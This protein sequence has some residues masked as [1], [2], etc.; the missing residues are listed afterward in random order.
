[1]GQISMNT[2]LRKKM[3]VPSV[4]PRIRANKLARGDNAEPRGA[5]K[6]VQTPEDDTQ[7]L[8]LYL[9]QDGNSPAHKKKKK[10][11]TVFILSQCIRMFREK[12]FDGS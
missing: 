4:P 6:K 1:L 11:H 9:A 10:E 2:A 7:L 5:K 3:R 12:K 8:F